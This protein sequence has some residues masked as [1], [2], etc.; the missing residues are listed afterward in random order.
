[1]LLLEDKNLREEF[2]SDI[3]FCEMDHPYW[4]SLYKSDVLYSTTG[5]CSYND[6]YKHALLWIAIRSDNRHYKIMH[7]ADGFLV[8]ESSHVI[9][10]RCQHPECRFTSSHSYLVVDADTLSD[11]RRKHRARHKK[12]YAGIKR[13]LSLES[14]LVLLVIILVALVRGL[15]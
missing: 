9:T 8:E 5:Q 12:S 15:I 10:Q 11:E 14:A 2:R 4:L 6:A 1:M 7:E 13:K 3:R